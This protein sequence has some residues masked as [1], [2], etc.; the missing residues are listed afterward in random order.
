MVAA[1][2]LRRAQTAAEA[3]APTPSKMAKVIANIAARHVGLRHAPPLLAGNG[4]RPGVTCSWSA[5]RDRGLAGALQFRRSSR[6]A[7]ERIDALHR[8]G[9]DVKIICVGRKGHEQLAPQLREADHR[10]RRTAG[11]QHAR[12]SPMPTTIAREDHRHVL[13]AASSM[14]CTLF[15]SPLQV[16]GLAD[17]DRRAADSA[18][19]DRGRRDGDPAAST[20]TSRRRTRSSKPAAAQHRACRCSARCW[21]TAGFVQGAQMSAM[22]NATRNAGDMIN[23]SRPSRSTARVRRRSPRN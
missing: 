1:A 2:K 3:R 22:D 6:L 17:S 20:I 16:G 11:V 5:P 23:A 18:C 8:Q 19:V 15:F 4:K 10:A 12:P 7:R 9:K 21:R 13:Q 14:S